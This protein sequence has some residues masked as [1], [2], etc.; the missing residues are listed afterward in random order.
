MTWRNL[1]FPL[2]NPKFGFAT[3]T[4]Y[5]LLAWA[6]NVNVAVYGLPEYGDVIHASLVGVIQNQSAV[7]W[8]ALLCGGFVLFTDTHSK[9]FR[10]IGGSLHALAHLTAVAA[11]GWWATFVTVQRFGLEFGTICQLLLAGA[12]I[13][14]LGW[15]VGP[16]IMGIYFIIALNGFGRHTNEAFSSLRSPDW[17]SFLRI[18][19]DPAGLTIY[20]I[21]F[22]KV[23]KA[24]RINPGGSESPEWVPDEQA[25]RSQHGSAPAL[26]ESPVFVS[27]T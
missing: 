15:L 5:V 24:W 9:W 6:V 23:W 20:P 14:A 1:L 17:K 18:K 21:G 7:M 11:L 2:I 8:M 26:I 25:P 10:W 13:F 4:L 19:V 12:L 16:M 22:R 27:H 3:A